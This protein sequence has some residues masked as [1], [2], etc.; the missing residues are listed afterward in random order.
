MFLNILHIHIV[1]LRVVVCAASV[2]I[3]GGRELHLHHVWWI[4]NIKVLLLLSILWWYVASPTAMPDK[5]SVWQTVIMH[6]WMS[7]LLL[8]QLVQLW[9]DG[10]VRSAS[11]LL[12]A[13]NVTSL[14]CCSR[15]SCSVET[16]L[17]HFLNHLHLIWSQNVLSA[18]SKATTITVLT[19]RDN[20]TL[21]CRNFI[22]ILIWHILLH[23]P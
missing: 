21:R 8:I 14:G 11:S 12:T 1:I 22:I 10:G 5:I 9:S 6:V 18:T 16:S 7:K 3:A 23:R 17:V 15:L 19:R 13:E 20:F 4:W 2:A